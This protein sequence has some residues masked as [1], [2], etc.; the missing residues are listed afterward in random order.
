MASKAEA[1]PKSKFDIG[2]PIPAATRSVGNPSQTAQD[3]I[4]CPVNQSFLEAIT[5]PE[6][7][8][9][10]S[11]RAKALA[12]EQTKVANRMAGA[13]RRHKIKNPGDEFVVRKVNDAELGT[14][15]RV[16]CT[17]KAAAAGAETKA[18]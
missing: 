7:V 8:K 10:E 17:A 12:D 3:L 15:V 9:D 14:G 16:Y 6:G 2:L 11:E 5:V 1:Q 4:D 13:I 18:G